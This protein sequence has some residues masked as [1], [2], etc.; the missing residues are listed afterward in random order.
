MAVPQNKEQLLAAI[1]TR[2]EKLLCTLN[3]VPTQWLDECTLEGHAKG[4]QMSVANLVAYLVGWNELV[5]KWLEMD[6]RG[7]VIDFPETGF[8]WNQ[9]GELAQKFYRD[10]EGIAFAQLLE[11]L[12]MAKQRIVSFIRSHANADLYECPWY[13]RWTMGRMIQFNT[14]S[15]YDNARGRLRKWLKTRDCKGVGHS[16]RVRAVEQQ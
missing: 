14:A 13:E 6:A 7:Q 15:P 10:Y 16:L 12:D 11:R 8:K 2:Y 3:S 4:T 5:L 1:E 9:L